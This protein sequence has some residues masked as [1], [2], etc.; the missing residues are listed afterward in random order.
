VWTILLIFVVF[1]IIQINISFCQVVGEEVERAVNEFADFGV[2]DEC[3]LNIER[4]TSERTR[5][6]ILVTD[7]T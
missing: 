6:F 5:L 7:S 1:Q 4:C 3:E 2:R